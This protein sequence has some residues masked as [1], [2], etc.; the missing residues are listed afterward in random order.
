MMEPI[1][2]AKLVDGT[3]EYKRAGDTVECLKVIKEQIILRGSTESL[4]NQI[5]REE[6]KV[7]EISG[8]LPRYYDDLIEAERAKELEEMQA[9]QEEIERLKTLWKTCTGEDYA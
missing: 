1:L 2:I 4:E 6:A 3:V 9:A 7:A 5:K 8:R